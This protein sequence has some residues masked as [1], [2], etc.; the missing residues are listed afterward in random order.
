M[1]YL[2]V[3]LSC[4][5]LMTALLQYNE[6]AVLSIMKEAEVVVIADVVKVYQSPG[7]WSGTVASVQHIKYEMVEV[8][9][10]E[11]KGKEI[12][13]GHYVVFNSLTADRDDARLS[14]KLF[15]P[16]NRIMLSLSRERGHGC[17]LDRPAKDVEAFCSPNENSGAVLAAPQ[18]VD[19]IRE[20]IKAN[21]L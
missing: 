2:S 7:F 8:L 9:K 5:F 18:L 3:I 1:S 6:K 11:V 16:G 17:K 4:T 21:D 20:G 13:V 14:P 12:D 15:N 10:G 19:K